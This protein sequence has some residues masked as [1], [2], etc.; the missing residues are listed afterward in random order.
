LTV[1]DNV[2]AG[3]LSATG[4]P[5]GF[6]GSHLRL[7][8]R[9]E[10]E[11]AFAALCQV[12]VGEKAFQRASDLSG[13]Q[14]QRVA[15][16][17][18]LAQGPDVLLADEPIASLDPRSATIVMDLLREIRESRG[19]PVVVNLHQVDV[20]KRYATRIVGMREVRVVFDGPPGDLDPVME[21]ALYDGETSESDLPVIL[22]ERACVS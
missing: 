17:R 3:R 22:K 1:L 2:L 19:M 11:Q 6:L 15:I 14:Q 4:M 12:G 13:G 10:R 21:R 8:S 7:F 16:A 20:A 18:V 5:F 9:D